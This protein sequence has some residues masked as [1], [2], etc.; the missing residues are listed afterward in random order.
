M[1]VSGSMMLPVSQAPSMCTG[2]ASSSHHKKFENSLSTE[3]EDLVPS[4]EDEV[5]G[6]EEKFSSFC[7]LL[8]IKMKNKKSYVSLSLY[9]R[10]IAILYYSPLINL[11]FKFILIFL[12]PRYSLALQ[13]YTTPAQHLDFTWSSPLTMTSASATTSTTTSEQTSYI[14][15]FVE[16]DRHTEAVKAL[17]ELQMKFGVGGIGICGVNGL[18]KSTLARRAYEHISPLFQ[19]HHYFINDSKKVYSYFLISPNKFIHIS[20]SPRYS[21]ALQVYTTPVQHLDFTW[22]SPFTM[23]STSATTSTTTSGQTSYIFRFVGMD[24]HTEAVKALLEFQMKVGV[25]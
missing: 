8:V 17:L 21:L 3:E 25:G 12:S 16:M 2:G 9:R 14:F 23:T 22:S 5:N 13:V 20:L 7:R 11:L 24:R 18:G 6:E 1:V 15:R 10:P 4:M 19:D